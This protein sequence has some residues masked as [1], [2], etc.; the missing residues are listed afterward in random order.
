MLKLDP[1]VLPLAVWAFNK[2]TGFGTKYSNPATTPATG[3]NV[4]AF[5]N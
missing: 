1:C 5:T 3:N 4:P 2:T